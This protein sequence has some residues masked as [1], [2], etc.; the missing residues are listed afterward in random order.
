MREGIRY[1][2]LDHAADLGVE[3]FASSVEALFVEAARALFDLM[4]SLGATEPRMQ[5][6]IVVEGEDQEELLRVWLSELLFRSSAR[7]ML[8]C[9]FD[10]LVL[11]S[12]RL[13]AQARGER[14]DPARHAFEREIKGVTFHGLQI[15]RE[16]QGWRA[17]VI[18]DI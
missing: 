16:P 8:F 18:F 6:S 3:V 15:V 1:R 12:R 4:G 2:L 7:A 9:E 13:H 11:D 17:T 5:E 14:F 10:I